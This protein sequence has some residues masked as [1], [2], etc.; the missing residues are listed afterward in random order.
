MLS[1]LIHLSTYRSIAAPVLLIKQ[2]AAA[3]PGATSSPFYR[4]SNRICLA[5]PPTRELREQLAG[6]NV[7][8][9]GKRQ[10]DSP[11]QSEAG[12]VTPWECLPRRNAAHIPSCP[13]VSHQQGTTTALQRSIAWLKA[14]SAI[15]AEMGP[16]GKDGR[17]NFPN[18]AHSVE[19]AKEFFRIY[20]RKYTEG[21]L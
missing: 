5:S 20:P 9:R 3:G 1:A 2:R 13:P 14:A 15:R 11:H 8:P 7:E 12:P 17:K 4:I 6:A 21:F 16:S 10:M 19:E 18:L